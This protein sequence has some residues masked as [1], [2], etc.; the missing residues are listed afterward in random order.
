MACKCHQKLANW[1]F[2]RD[3]MGVA[4]RYSPRHDGVR[5]TREITMGI[6]KWDPMRELEDM[7]LRLN[8]MFGSNAL[9][10]ESRENLAFPDWQPTVDI[11][12]TPEAFV[13]RAELP[14][15]K[16]EDIKVSISGGVLS[17]SGERK[18]EKEHKDEKTH[19]VERSYGSFMRSFTLPDIVD[20]GQVT[21]QAKDGVLTVKVGKRHETKPKS[22]EIKVH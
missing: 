19:R 15:V 7:T 6:V 14:E 22:V 13:I 1:A 9:Q 2:T 18:R 16:K 20:S 5:T 21:A 12:E 8:R 11:S 10:T 3:G 17:L 4:R